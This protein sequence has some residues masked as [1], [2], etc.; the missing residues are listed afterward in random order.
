MSSY[1]V[2][3]ASSLQEARLKAESKTKNKRFIFS[4][5][6]KR[7]IIPSQVVHMQF[8]KG[9]IT[10]GIPFLHTSVT[11]PQL[12]RAPL[13]ALQRIIEKFST[14]GIATAF[15]ELTHTPPIGMRKLKL[16]LSRFAARFQ[17]CIHRSGI[18]DF[19]HDAG[20]SSRVRRF[21]PDPIT[22]NR[23][24]DPIDIENTVDI[25]NA[26]I[27]FKANSGAHTAQHKKQEESF[28]NR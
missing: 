21:D 9:R 7:E 2:L 26:R 14:I 25:G 4:I 6:Y 20:A 1:S 28:H 17:I 16:L 8:A 13:K 10:I 24:L 11:A 3:C 22:A 19:L 15:G 12:P 18:V 5:F 27:C 23:V